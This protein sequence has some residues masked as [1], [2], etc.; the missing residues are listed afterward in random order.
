MILISNTQIYFKVNMYIVYLRR[1]LSVTSY[2][3]YMN[4]RIITKKNYKA[5]NLLSKFTLR[6][7]KIFLCQKL[8]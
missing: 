5:N 1:Q 3:K 4:N 7:N 2:K 8:D 6:F